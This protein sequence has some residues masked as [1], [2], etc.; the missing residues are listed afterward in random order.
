MKQRAKTTLM[1]V[2]QI[3]SPGCGDS[4]EVEGVLLE[5]APPV[6]LDT[7]LPLLP[8]PKQQWNVFM[9]R[10]SEHNPAK[11]AINCDIPRRWADS[12]LLPN[13]THWNIW[14]QI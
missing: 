9:W 13:M 6:M 3:L 8:N 11:C 7:Y 14:P 12:P 1:F 2:K 10:L 5:A 4:P